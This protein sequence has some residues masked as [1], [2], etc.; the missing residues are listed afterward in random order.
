MAKYI[1]SFLVAAA[2]G[3]VS[4]SALDVETTA[5]SLSSQ[6]TNPAGVTELKLSGVLNADDFKF[7]DESMTSLKSLDLGNVTIA[8]TECNVPGMTNAYPAN[9]IP[10]NAFGGSKIESVVFPTSTFSLGDGAFAGSAIKSL[11]L[12]LS[13][14]NVG[15]GCF[16]GCTALE[17]VTVANG[18]LG[19]GVFAGCSSLA[20]I[21]FSLPNTAI[22]A[23]TFSNCTAL[24]TVSGSANITSI[25][26]RAFADCTS[27]SSFSFG[28]SLRSIGEEA[29]I[30]SGLTAVDLSNVTALKEIGAWAF[31]RMPQLESLKM[32]SSSQLSEGMVFDCP[33][34][35]E[36]VISGQATEIPDY[37][38]AK[39]TSLG[40]PGL[41]EGA[42]VR[43]G[44]HS[45]HGMSQVQDVSLPETL[46]EIGDG[47]MQNMTGLRSIT[48]NSDARPAIDKDVWAGVEQSQV[49][50][51]VPKGQYSDYSTADQWCNFH[52]LDVSNSVDAVIGDQLDNLKG[53]FVGDELQVSISGVEIDEIAVYDPAGML[54]VSGE[55]VA[56]FVSL[57]MAGFQTRVFIVNARLSDGRV[58][59]LKIAKR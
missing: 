1:F 17:S 5:G 11:T 35:K 25:G 2:F 8:A 49:N 26:S 18:T 45:M 51:V 56:E 33:V 19:V 27:L 12:P 13:V 44:N 16:S 52:V 38:F 41:L 36:F 30:C 55:P 53:R 29:F 9:T 37:A 32:S 48:V 28:R 57:D 58:A 7:I 46:E 22:P 43:I 20:T 24:S 39:N 50:L 4:V 54:L 59:S 47:A 34:L 21:S 10:A 15:D 23:N 40:D 42:I 6:V 14:A 31:A 3:T